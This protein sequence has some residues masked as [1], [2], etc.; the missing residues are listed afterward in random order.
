M[1]LVT[2]PHLPDQG[3]ASTWWDFGDGAGHGWVVG[4]GKD[5]DQIYEKMNAKM[6]AKR[7]GEWLQKQQSRLCAPGTWIPE[8]YVSL[9]SAMPTAK[10]RYFHARKLWLNCRQSLLWCLRSRTPL[11]LQ[12]ERIR[13]KTYTLL[14]MA[15]SGGHLGRPRRPLVAS[16]VCAWTLHVFLG[17]RA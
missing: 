3:G 9:R 11:N 4:R 1:R 6:S 7:S 8:D 14:C 5:Q 12:V 10:S 13:M 16:L 15:V 17:R 2:H